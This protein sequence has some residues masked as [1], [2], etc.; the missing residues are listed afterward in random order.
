MGA[1][2]EVQVL[3]AFGPRAAREHAA[4]KLCRKYAKGRRSAEQVVMGLEA[5]KARNDDEGVCDLLAAALFVVTPVPTLVWEWAC[6]HADLLQVHT[7]RHMLKVAGASARCEKHL[8]AHKD[9]L[10][11]SPDGLVALAHECH[12]LAWGPDLA[13]PAIANL[14]SRLPPR[15]RP[16]T[17]VKQWTQSSD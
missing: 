2:A 10:V 3:R 9:R 13:R 11:A 6:R 17:P 16:A 15:D 1:C 14:L 8:L 5:L 12:R 4:L 7:L